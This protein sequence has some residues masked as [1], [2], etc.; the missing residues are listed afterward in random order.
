MGQFVIPNERSEDDHMD[1][2]MDVLM[3]RAQDVQERRVGGTGTGK[4]PVE[5]SRE[6]RPRATPGAVAEGSCFPR[7]VEQQDFPVALLLRNDRICHPL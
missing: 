1:L 2:Y 5:S 6:R 4:Y 7:N 3:P